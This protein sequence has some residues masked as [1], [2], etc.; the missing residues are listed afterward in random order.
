MMRLTLAILTFVLV[1]CTPLSY[2]STV[3]TRDTVP[4]A[5]ELSDRPTLVLVD[6]PGGQ[7][8]SA[9]LANVV[10]DKIMSDLKQRELVIQFVALT[11]LQALADALG[12]DYATTPIDLIGRRLGAEQVL[13]VKIAALQLLGE[14]S[15]LRPRARVQVKVIDAQGSARLFPAPGDGLAQ[16]YDLL[17]EMQ[18]RYGDNADPGESAMLLREVAERIGRD[19]ARLFYEYEPSPPGHMLHD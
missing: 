2:I 9:V 17:V 16:G 14:P 11:E 7:L 1:G 12:D 8:G 19:V 10:A 18:H 4:A 15:M 13:Y 5:Y 3:I 6:D